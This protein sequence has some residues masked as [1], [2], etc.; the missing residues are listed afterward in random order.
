M[1]NVLKMKLLTTQTP[2]RISYLGG[3]SDF[4]EFTQESEGNVLG[5]T[6]DW[7]VYTHFLPIPVIAKENYRITYRKTESVSDISQ[8]EHPVVQAML[9][10]LS[11]TAPLNIATLSDVPGRTGLGSSSSFTVGL[12]S[13]LLAL[14]GETP[15]PETLAKLAIDIER[16]HLN[17]PGGMQDQCHAAFGGFRRYNFFKDDFHA[18]L[19]LLDGIELQEFSKCNLLVW[20]AEPR[21]NASTSR[22]HQNSLKSQSG[23]GLGKELSELALTAA[24]EIVSDPTWH[25]ALSVISERL[26]L[27]WKIKSELGGIQP[28]EKFEHLSHI[29]LKFGVKARKMLGSG[30]SGFGL[31]LGYPEQILKLREALPKEFTHIPTLIQSGTKIVRFE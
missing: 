25:H 28:N 14:R 30:D 24:D 27:N 4:Q 20:I 18:T 29:A 2:L 13:G 11:W 17:E 22:I 5:C 12:A 1:S 21:I 10:H 19:P 26:D 9:S 8:I 7:F 15:S 16:N 6:F 3:G 31:F 23:N